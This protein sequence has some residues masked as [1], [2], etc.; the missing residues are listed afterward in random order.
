[1]K[2]QILF[3][4]PLF[5]L[6]SCSSYSEQAFLR[7]AQEGLKTIDKTTSLTK[8]YAQPEGHV[9]SF[10]K[11]FFDQ[12][13]EAMVPTLEPVDGNPENGFDFGSSYALHV[14]IRI[15]QDTFYPSDTSTDSAE[16]AFSTFNFIMNFSGDPQHHIDYRNDEG[17]HVFFVNDIS[18]E[19]RIGNIKTDDNLVK[20]KDVRIYA[21]FDISTTYDKDGFLKE[22]L[23]KTIGAENA[24]QND[25]VYYRVTYTYA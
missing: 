11:F 12:T 3:L 22:E 6:A 17:N 14:P 16:F 19:C 21:R 25:T 8:Y 5:L 13:K 23:I 24:P 1:M 15:S 20:A 2:K 18:K 9:L 7:K 10:E 4:L